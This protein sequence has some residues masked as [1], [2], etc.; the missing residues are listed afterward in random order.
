MVHRDCPFLV[1]FAKG[2]RQREYHFQKKDILVKNIK[3]KLFV[4]LQEQKDI[5]AN[6]L[7]ILKLKYLQTS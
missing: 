3:G 1:F 6:R 4:Y 5:L 7:N 2:P